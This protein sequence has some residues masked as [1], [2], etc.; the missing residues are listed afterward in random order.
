MEQEVP[1]IAVVGSSN[2]DLVVKSN[3]IPVTGETI[4]GGDF[5][6]VPGGKGANQAVAAAKL[7]ARVFFIAKLGDDIF[8]SQSLNNFEKEGVNTKYVLQTKDAPSGVAL[9]MVDDDGNN[10]IVVAPGA[11]LKLKQE[12]VKE[13]E[14]D[15]ALSGALVAQLEVPIETI[16]FAAGL[17]NKSNVPFILDP[18]PAQKL[19]QELLN[20]VDVLTPNETEAKILTGIEVKDRNSASA[21][22]QKLLE[23]G[24]K[25]V[26]LT[27]GATGYLSVGKEGKEFIAARKVTAADSTA[28]GDAFT[29]SLAVGLA[30]GQT[31]SQAALFA[32]NVAAFSVT[33][34]GA[35]P[36]M[37]T[38]EEIDKFIHEMEQ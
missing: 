12:D 11:N 32:N 25:N 28:A 5:I 24:V 27:M 19:S 35:Q 3:R 18:A 13:A 38:I 7:G 14:S 15:I 2:M 33:R 16:E 23:C 30:K 9:I 26:I 17:A 36:S 31:L 10:V 34:M 29:G 20:M 4:L 21:A 1:T 6:M 37:P 22:A 8:G